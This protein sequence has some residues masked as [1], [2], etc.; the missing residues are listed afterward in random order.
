MVYFAKKFKIVKLLVLTLIL[1]SIF[2][3]G[4]SLLV[5]AETK[6]VYLG[7]YPAGFTITTVGAEVL[8]LSDVVTDGGVVS[9]ARE[10]GIKENDLILNTGGKETNTFEDIENVLNGCEGKTLMI[11]IK[12]GEE[13]QI[14]EITPVL[15]LSGKYKLGLYV[16]DRLSGIGTITF[17]KNDGEF[18]ALGHP[19]CNEDEKVINIKKGEIFGCNIFGVERG[20]RG[21]AGELRGMFIN[22]IKIGI[23]T[24]NLTVGIKG[25]LDSSFD[26][27]KLSKIEI[28]EAHPGNASI[29]TT[30]EGETPKEFSIAI[31]K[32][33]RY[34][35]DNRNFVI[36]ITDKKLLEIAGGIVQGMSGSPI[37]QDGKL[38][39]AITHVFLNDPSR[40]FGIN[41]ENMLNA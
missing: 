19:I 5:N 26:K 31:V 30:V 24:N 38:V 36:K 41:I 25:R 3:S 37:V 21:K 16:R 9:P 14:K 17:I 18:M 29:F 1:S 13:V 33:D 23:I 20:E 15:D 40:G 27:S 35:K 34:A 10:I 11:T 28:G 6:N 7:G 4:Q 32:S 22:D 39:G 12:R 2:L 8:G